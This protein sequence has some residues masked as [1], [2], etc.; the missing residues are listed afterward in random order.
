VRRL[1]GI[2]VLAA[3]LVVAPSGT[4][5]VSPTVRLTIAHVVRHCHVWRT[6]TRTLGAAAKITVK[7]G[8]RLVIRS[9]CPMDFDYA[10]TSGARLPLG[11][12]RTRAGASRVI[13]FRKAGIYRLTATNVETPEEQGLATLGEP[14]TLRLTV[15]VE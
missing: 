7:R 15:V 3:G 13:V 12:P 1:V 2:A 10:Q 11:N 6:T 9:D 14:N 5:A 8:A 4:A